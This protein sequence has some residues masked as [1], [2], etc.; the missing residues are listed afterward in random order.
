MPLEVSNVHG[1][2]YIWLTL[3]RLLAFAFNWGLLGAL[4]VQIYT[5][6]ISF[7]DPLLF[8][9]LDIA[10][11][12]SATYD[13][14]QWFGHEWGNPDALENLYS[15]YLN[16]PL[17]TSIIGTAVQIFFG[18]RIWCFSKS[19]ILYGF[20]ISLAF[21][22]LVGAVVTSYYLVKFPR[23][24]H[25]VAV[26]P[27]SV[28]VRLGT[29]A[30]VDIVVAACM[31][32][33]LLRGRNEFSMNTNAIIT[34]LVRL[35]V[36]TG[37]I[38]AAAAILDL[39]FFLSLHR[40]ALHQLSGVTLSKL[41]TNSLLMLFNNRIHIRGGA[42]VEERSWVPSSGSTSNSAR[43][44]WPFGTRSTPTES[45]SLELQAAALFVLI[46]H[47]LPRPTNVSDAFIAS[48]TLR[49]TVILSSKHSP[50]PRYG[51]AR[52]RPRTTYKR[53]PE[54]SSSKEPSHRP[55]DRADRKALELPN[56]I[57]D[58]IVDETHDL[59]PL[60]LVSRQ[61]YNAA[62]SRVYA[63]IA[64]SSAE[65]CKY[66]SRKFRKW[67]H[68][69]GFVRDMTLSDANDD[70]LGSPYMRSQPAR[71]LFAALTG[72]RSLDVQSF[73]RWGPV[74]HRLLK[75][76]RTV[77]LLSLR[78]IPGMSRT[79][80][81]HDLVQSFPKLDSLLLFSGIGQAYDFDNR[82]PPLISG[83]EPIP[84]GYRPTRL[85]SVLSL[86]DVEIC[87]DQ[88]EWLTSPAFDTTK[89]NVLALKWSKFPK[90]RQTLS[91]PSFSAF[92]KLITQ[93]GSTISILDF[94]FPSQ[95][96]FRH[97][98]Q[99]VA[100]MRDPDDLLTAHIISS[101]ILRHA[102][103]LKEF[104]L[105]RFQMESNLGIAI[106][107]AVLMLKTLTTPL[108]HTIEL[109]AGAA[110]SSDRQLEEYFVLP[111]WRELDELL[112]GD[113]FPALRSVE[114]NLNLVG[115][116]VH[117]HTAWAAYWLRAGAEKYRSAIET[118]G[119]PKVKSKGKLNLKVT[120]D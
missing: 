68:L 6:H 99:V 117:H 21:V 43:P 111:E 114:F 18:W 75:S 55:S 81:L 102:T 61:W 44:R 80:D 41:Y 115:G 93:V 51:M 96:R 94:G 60:T 97:E 28:G 42:P 14:A 118:R 1:E 116:G 77:D 107:T 89:L 23:E 17:L 30:A 47:Q 64:V 76:L 56:E 108:I 66:W 69:G 15:T 119:L 46:H 16:V 57:V 35:T 88:L 2:D 86:V 101:K 54:R 113:T 92:N 8:R 112:A 106:C 5:Y 33:Y 13:A 74:E 37:T 12:C 85:M 72:L 70:C 49:F 79:K 91:P 104:R 100:G 109:S 39:V 19:R 105:T 26:L 40:N 58:L 71:S 48:S 103:A 98:S 32:Y 62:Q 20:I 52:K 34:K 53:D 95:G 38:T 9:V 82:S 67:P 3:P 73:K 36:E 84:P 87:Q 31:T 63:H 78:D 90:S 27:I 59:V 83:E 29:S 24:G 50:T 25:P 22:Q 10:Q 7:R 120:K 65:A 11:T 4:T 45:I 110:A